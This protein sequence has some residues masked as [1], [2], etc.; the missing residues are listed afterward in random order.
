MSDAT[1]AGYDQSSLDD[2]EFKEDAVREEFTGPLLIRL[3]YRSTG[4]N[5][6]IRS[7]HLA[8]PFVM[9]GTTKTP[10]GIIPDYLLEVAGKNVWVLDAKAPNE[11]ITSGKNIQQ[12]FSYAIHPDIHVSY[13]ALCNG[14]EFVLFDVSTRE[15]LLRFKMRDLE[16]NWRA[17]YGFLSPS[18]FGS[19]PVKARGKSLV[20]RDFDYL[21]TKPPPEI[22]KFQKQAAK[23]YHG[24]HGYFTRQVWSVVQRYIE[25]FTRPGDLVL[26]PFGGSGVTLIES[27]I[28]GRRAIQ[29]DI[30]PL[31]KFIVE[32]EVSKVDPGVLTQNYHKVIADFDRLRPRTPTQITAALKKYRCQFASNRDPLFASNRD[33]SGVIGL[34]LSA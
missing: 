29:I 32:T 19:S 26:D 12:A 6:I 17:I 28:L 15:P 5:R 34:G 3:G 31:A 4:E 27:L 2:S 30:N 25:T 13:Y 16:E 14:R 20:K 24:V 33:P 1:E 22:T 11:V 23:R 18:A 7:R 9:I 10:V 21:A 8:H